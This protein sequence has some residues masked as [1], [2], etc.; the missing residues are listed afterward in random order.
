MLERK[1][2]LRQVL[3]QGMR[4]DT[5]IWLCDKLLGKAARLGGIKLERSPILGRLGKADIEAAFTLIHRYT[6][7]DR[8][9]LICLLGAYNHYTVVVEKTGNQLKL[10]DSHGFRWVALRSCELHHRGAKS[11]HQIA[12][13]SAAVIRRVG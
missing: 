2:L 4:E 11:R 3:K 13:H 8:P 7:L 10:F 1:G 6:R 5:W 9:V 12:R